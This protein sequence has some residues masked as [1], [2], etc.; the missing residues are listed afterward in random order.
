LRRARPWPSEL[1][2]GEFCRG[3]Y[4]WSES[5]REHLRRLFID[6]AA[7]LSDILA[8]RNE[9][10][11]AIDL[12]DRAIG[13][14][15]YAEH[16]YRKAMALESKRGRRDGVVRRFRRLERLLSEELEVSPENEAVAL[17]RSLTGSSPK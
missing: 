2:R 15:K 9:L 1:Y 10:D 16:L 14:D 12:V 7:R 3:A 5:T 4:S 17:F 11:A 13:A 6:S 8:E